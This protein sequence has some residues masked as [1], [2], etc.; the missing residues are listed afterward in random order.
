VHREYKGEDE[1]EQMKHSQGSTLHG[2]KKVHCSELKG[3]H[4]S[5]FG[6]SQQLLRESNIEVEHGDGVD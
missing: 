4:P 2:Y 1:E 6:C 5:I 3:W